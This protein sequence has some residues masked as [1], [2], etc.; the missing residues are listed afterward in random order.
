MAFSPDGHLLA[1]GSED[2]TANVWD[3]GVASWQRHLYDLAGRN[4]TRQEWDEFLPERPYQKTCGGR[5]TS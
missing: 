1:T 4:L 5:R 2:R 3:M